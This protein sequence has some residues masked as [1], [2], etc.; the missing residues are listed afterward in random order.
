[1]KEQI[2]KLI[3]QKTEFPLTAFRNQIP[4]ITGGFD[5]IFPSK[6]VENSNI[7]LMA[8]VSEEFILTMRDLISAQVLTFE[9]T[10]PL[11]VS[12]D[13]GEFYKL[14]LVKRRQP[15]YKSLHWLPLMIKRGKNF[16]KVAS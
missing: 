3:R 1:M 4:E 2:L 16:P 6:G 12:F 9:P 13:G 8:K 11:L 5:F 14:P 7:L 10:D 15:A